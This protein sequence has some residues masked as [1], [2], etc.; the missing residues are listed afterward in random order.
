MEGSSGKDLTILI[1]N[2]DSFTYNVYQYLC[3]LSPKSSRVLVFRNDAISLS[4]LIDMSPTRLVVSPGPGSPHV[5]SDVGVSLLAIAYF[6]GK[7]PILGICLGHQCIVAHFGGVVEA[8]KR[9]SDGFHEIVHGK[10]ARLVHDGKGVFTNVPEKCRVVRY[11]SLAAR[12][13]SLPDVLE[14][15]AKTEDSNIIMGVRHKELSV[16]GVQFHP[17][18]ILTES[19]KRMLENFLKRRKGVWGS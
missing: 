8:A 1:D 2:Y 17:E 15:T 6:S 3:E 7:I 4:S 16:E 13:S 10:T 19:G 12:P 5:A 9:P 18:S 14:V 11:H